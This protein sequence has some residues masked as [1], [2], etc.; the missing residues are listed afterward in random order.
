MSYRDAPLTPLFVLFD[1]MLIALDAKSGRKLWHQRIAMGR[2]RLFRVPEA[3]LVTGSTSVAAYDL[4]T[5]SPLGS[6]ELGFS[7]DSGVV[8]DGHLYLAGA[9]MACLDVRGRLLWRVARVS[10]STGLLSATQTLVGQDAAGTTIWSER[11][12][13]CPAP[14][15]ALAIGDA[16]AQA[17]QRE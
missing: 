5:G 14:P 8:H 11:I 6:V 7:V 10:Q 13:F 17:D 16:L 1:E 15:C 9:G 4:E 3:V 2:H 12:D